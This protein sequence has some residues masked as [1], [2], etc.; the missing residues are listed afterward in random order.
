[1]IEAS[2]RC[3]LCVALVVLVAVA[4]F[5]SARDVA[6]SLQQA[7]DN[8]KQIEA[9]LAGAPE[10]QRRAVEFLVVNMPERDLRSLSGDY[11]LENVRLAYQAWEES[12]W[13]DR[14]DEATFFNNVL[15]YAVVN[16][17]RD[18]WRPDFYQ[19]FAPLVKYAKSPS[20]A[21]ALLNNK[22]FQQLNVRY[23]TQRRKADQ[24]PF[25]SM[26][27]GLASC[28]GLSV[29]LIDACRAVGVPARFAGTPLWSDRSGNHSWVEVWDDGWHF[30]GAAE[31]TA[32]KL[33]EGWFV[34]RAA[35]ADGDDP[36]HAIYAVSFQ[37]T[38]LKFPCVWDRRID[39]VF[40][41]NATSR[42]VA[43]ST[44]LPA[45]SGFARFRVLD[46]DGR[47]V[48]AEIDVR[49]ENGASVFHG[50]THDESFDA[51]DH[52][53]TILPRGRTFTVT[54]RP[55]D[56]GDAAQAIES[57]IAIASDEQL[58]TLVSV[59]EATAQEGEHAV[60]P[61]VELRRY[62]K[63]A[64]SKR[65]EL[66]SLAW[67]AVPLSR[68]QAQQAERLLWADH[69]ARMRKERRREVDDGV[70][71]IGDLKMP[72]TAKVFGKKPAEGRS[73]FLSMH[74]GGGAPKQVNDQ[75]WQNQQ[76]LY[77]PDEGVYI[78]PRAPT[79]AWNLW[80]QTHID[81]FFDRLIEDF[82]ALEE[83]DPNRV[84][85]MGYSAGGDGAYQLAPRMADR[86]AAVAMMAGHPNDASPLGL[87]NIGFALF[88]G[89]RDA[90]YQRNAVAAE[91]RDRL[92]QLQ[93]DDPGG[94]RHQATIY[95]DKG[96]WMDRE[97]ASAL[98]W[99]SQFRRDPRPD[100]VVWKQDDVTHNRFYWLH[101][102]QPTAGAL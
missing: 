44:M 91:W 96:H 3:R 97:D 89:G 79:D 28:T 8:A 49:N 60:A 77:E 26:E 12:P 51:N 36:R 53:T 9:A 34:E 31:P 25:E 29:L 82:V 64:G 47:R 46:P 74:G 93:A 5:A 16:E 35:R 55:R 84:Y 87:R 23:S 22:I 62:L 20:E 73:L 70:V 21:A 68:E 100:K 57:N 13:H 69:V 88:M 59:D 101:V 43:G 30:T 98:P 102:A 81:D 14:I 39:D 32:M 72:F 4:D 10:R 85:L 45:G 52:L 24:S 71:Q 83:V 94:Y 86:W 42:Y 38:P 90:A 58:V 6:V 99:M 66:T 40:A 17:R 78:A 61:L 76:R 2:M 75:Q 50:E 27:S 80:H 67:A 19:R 56:T 92:A 11:L 33:D 1:M 15:P 95:P 48:R 37:R 41:V 54:A 18:A 7:G 63:V 65:P